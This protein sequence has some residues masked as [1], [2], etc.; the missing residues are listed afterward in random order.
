MRSFEGFSS[1]QQK[2]DTRDKLAEWVSLCTTN[3]KM[4]PYY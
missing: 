2:I 3:S 1:K 4:N